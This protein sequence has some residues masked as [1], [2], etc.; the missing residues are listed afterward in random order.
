MYSFPISA[1]HWVTHMETLHNYPVFV[2]CPFL[3]ILVAVFGW[4]PGPCCC[5]MEHLP[6]EGPSPLFVPALLTSLSK[7]LFE[8]I[9]YVRMVSLSAS[10]K[11]QRFLLTPSLYELLAKTIEPQPSKPWLVQALLGSKAC[12]LAM[13]HACR[14]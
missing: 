1:D 2:L 14:N 8:F 4:R 7:K 9:T 10:P 6:D 5:A 12:P 11:K 13:G 3:L